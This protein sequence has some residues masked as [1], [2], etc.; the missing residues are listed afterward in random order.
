VLSGG[1]AHD[2]IGD[3]HLLSSMKADILLA[4]KACDGDERVISLLEN[5]GKNPVIPPMPRTNGAKSPV[6]R[7]QFE[8]A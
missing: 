8:R 2:L 7:Q 3:D 6:V 1:Q 5:T 4:D